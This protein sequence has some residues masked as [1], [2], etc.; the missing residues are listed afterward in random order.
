MQTRG[1]PVPRLFLLVIVVAWLSP[2]ARAQDSQPTS[3]PGAPT[4]APAD[5]P[6]PKELQSPDAFVAWLCEHAPTPPD[7]NDENHDPPEESLAASKDWR[8]TLESYK[9]RRVR[10]RFLFQR[11]AADPIGPGCT[12][13]GRTW[14]GYSVAVHSIQDPAG[15]QDL[16]VGALL[17]TEATL[18][19]FQFSRTRD[20]QGLFGNN[21]DMTVTF[22]ALLRGQVKLIDADPTPP[23]KAPP[24]DRAAL[25]KKLFLGGQSLP[26]PKH[27]VLLVDTHT[28]MKPDWATVQAQ[29][30]EC[31]SLLPIET[32]VSLGLIGPGT[33]FFP[34]SGFA[35]ATEETTEPL[36]EKITTSRPNTANTDPTTAVRL[37]MERLLTVDDSLADSGVFLV[38]NESLLSH[39]KKLFYV[40]QHHRPIRKLQLDAL[41][42]HIIL[43]RK[44]R[45]G[46]GEPLQSLA[47]KLTAT[48]HHP[49]QKNDTDGDRP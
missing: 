28:N 43:V 14:D 27:V 39:Q 37:A 21:R 32:K 44:P 12:I 42:L 41:P 6:V 3:R 36:Q 31:L 30:Q 47:R 16:P 46:M 48:F 9:G 19:E 2:W 45:H 18:D 29:L 15:L 40:M 7:K 33:V 35:D 20:S 34:K 4:S 5:V 26:C 49:G 22:G 13:L 8:E 17:E 25:P 23:A 24:A 38:T 11:V 10:W 1:I